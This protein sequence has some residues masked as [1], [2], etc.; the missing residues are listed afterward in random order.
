MEILIW[1][2]YCISKV[3]VTLGRLLCLFFFFNVEKMTISSLHSCSNASS[4]M[5]WK[6]P[7]KH[8]WYMYEKERWWES[9][10]VSYKPKN[11]QVF[12]CLSPLRLLPSW[13]REMT[14][15]CSSHTASQLH[16]PKL[17][18]TGVGR[19]QTQTFLQEKNL[20]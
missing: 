4:R 19:S 3:C 18:I 16:F 14:L 1:N 9:R 8:Y 5:L 2:T 17:R 15:P 11:R 7:T 13:I 6:T 20:L 12:G 10:G